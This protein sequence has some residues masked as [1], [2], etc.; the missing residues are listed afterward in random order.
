MQASR[1]W[2]MILL[3]QSLQIIL[4]PGI[5]QHHLDSSPWSC[6]AVPY[7]ITSDGNTGKKISSTNMHVGCSAA[8]STILTDRRWRS[9][10]KKKA[11]DERG[12][13]GRKGLWWEIMFSEDSGVMF[14]VK[15]MEIIP[16]S[17][18]LDAVLPWNIN[19]E[20][21]PIAEVMDTYWI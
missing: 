21:L 14:I 15:I 12:Q 5:V 3:W 17:H 18:G 4:F 8:V 6:C 11:W 16:Y 13:V 19:P 10:D 1:L 20:L 2:K 9:R 7:F